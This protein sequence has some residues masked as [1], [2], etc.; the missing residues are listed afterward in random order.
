M[1][2]RGFNGAGGGIAGGGETE[3][4]T[5]FWTRQGNGLKST[6]RGAAFA[7]MLLELLV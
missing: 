5:T 7:K 4:A 3:V 2:L 6:P 1:R